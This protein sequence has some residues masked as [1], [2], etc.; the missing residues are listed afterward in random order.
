VPADPSSPIPAALTQ[1]AHVDSLRPVD[2]PHLLAFLATIHDPR[3]ASG[4]DDLAEP[5]PP[6]GV[7]VLLRHAWAL[8][9]FSWP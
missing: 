5:W 1:L 3:Q 4:R 7:R 6:A 9:G 2:A 8:S